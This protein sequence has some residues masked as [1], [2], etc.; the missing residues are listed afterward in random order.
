[1]TQKK[2]ICKKLPNKVFPQLCKN[3]GEDYKIELVGNEDSGF[4]TKEK[5]YIFHRGDNTEFEDAHI[6]Y[7]YYRA[8]RTIKGRK[9]HQ[10]YVKVP[11]NCMYLYEVKDE[12]YNSWGDGGL[13]NLRRKHYP[14]S[15]CAWRFW[16][17]VPTGFTL[18]DI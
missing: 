10:K 15:L 9:R 16:G 11:A 5:G 1:L 8:K 3:P 6:F 14:Y 17:E 18:V 7:T 12:D 13:R 4:A 2:R